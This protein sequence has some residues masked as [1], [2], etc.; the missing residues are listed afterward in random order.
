M[1]EI[2]IPAVAIF[3][4]FGLPIIAMLAAIL[5]SLLEKPRWAL[6]N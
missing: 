2:L 1:K 3:S 6:Q 4:L 5:A